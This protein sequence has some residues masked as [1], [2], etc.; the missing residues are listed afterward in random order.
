MLPGSENCVNLLYTDY[1]STYQQV[2]VDGITAVLAAAEK[3]KPDLTIAMLH[4][5]SEYNDTISKSQEEICELLVQRG[6]D[7]ILGTHSHFLQKM[8]LDPTTGQFTAYSLGDFVGD[9]VRPGSNYSV[10]LDLE[11]TKDNDAGTTSITGFDYTPV[12]LLAEEGKPL[13]V[14][15]IREAISA[16]E[17]AQLGRVSKEVYESMLYALERIDN[18]I[19]G[20]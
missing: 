13:Q 17:N 20:E 7:A 15:R 3:E 19:A 1:T 5:G 16:Y 2:N 6:V 8:T 9:A 18:R 14:L 11:I 12:Y 4:W 10:I